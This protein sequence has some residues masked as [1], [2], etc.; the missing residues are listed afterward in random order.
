MGDMT[1]FP[2]SH[3]DLLD[4]QIGT[5]ATLGAS[6]VPQQTAVWF[7]HDEGEIRLSLNSVRL[8]TRNLAARPQCSLLILDLENPYRY[9]EVH[10]HASLVPDDDYA[11]AKKVGAKYGGADLS[12]HDGPGEG[13]VV[14]TIE[15]TNVYAVD[16][17]G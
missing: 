10:G 16:M 4:A 11:F 1:T 2:D 12:E 8:K 9:L 15:P 13:R 3:S 7:L 14:V 6:G 5:L 17:S